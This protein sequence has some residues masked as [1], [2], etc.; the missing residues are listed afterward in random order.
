MKIKSTVLSK[1][2]QT[3]FVSGGQQFSFFQRRLFLHLKAARAT[4]QYN[5]RPHN[6]QPVTTL[7]RIAMRACLLG[8]RFHFGRDDES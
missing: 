6:I 5:I 4:L 3:P 8:E 7:V 1:T 2:H